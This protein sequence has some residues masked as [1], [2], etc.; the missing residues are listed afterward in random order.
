MG[1]PS[2]DD[3]CARGKHIYTK[4]LGQWICIHCGHVK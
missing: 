4:I 1:K 3:Y 2:Q